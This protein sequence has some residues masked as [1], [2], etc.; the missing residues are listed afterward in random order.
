MELIKAK[1]ETLV[2]QNN[3]WTILLHVC[4]GSPASR[5]KGEESHKK[6]ALQAN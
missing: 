1:G 4:S 2:A 6:P 3:G 5:L